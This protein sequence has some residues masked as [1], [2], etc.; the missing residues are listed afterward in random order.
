M[1]ASPL[2]HRWKF[3]LLATLWLGCAVA[4]AQPEV[5][6]PQ[7]SPADTGAEAADRKAQTWLVL[8]LLDP[9]H[10]PEQR[11]QFLR[12]LVL[13]AEQGNHGAATLLGHLYFLGPEHPSGLLDRRLDLAEKYFRVALEAGDP[14]ALTALAEIELARGNVGDALVLVQAYL[15]FREHIGSPAAEESYAVTLL[16]R[17]QGSGRRSLRQEALVER[18]QAVMDSHGARMLAH[19]ATEPASVTGMAWTPGVAPSE[20]RDLQPKAESV[21]VSRTTRSQLTSR[22]AGGLAHYLISVSPQGEVVDVVMLS[23]M[24][25]AR[26]AED[27]MASVR[28]NTSYSPV[29]EGCPLRWASLP[30]DSSDFRSRMR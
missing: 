7:S 24:P 28:A 30:V 14:N 29:D 6:E 3:T 16:A 22:W 17:A 4:I 26:F 12:N 9:G 25:H 2:G 27:M 11:Q 23:S 18:V 15:I 1:E 10:P 13:E 8:D 20:C 21:P 5:E 19:D